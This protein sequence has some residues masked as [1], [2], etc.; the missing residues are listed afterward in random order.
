ML[1]TL[2]A[3]AQNFITYHCNDGSEVVAAFYRG[4][5]RV[6]VQLDGKALTLSKR[7]SLTG[8]RFGR[9][10]I[11]FTI[12]KDGSATLKRG[13]SATACTNAP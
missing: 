2:P 9:G 11:S 4:D 6:H 3:A 13:R 1:A 10:D 8:T 5:S 12:A 7:I